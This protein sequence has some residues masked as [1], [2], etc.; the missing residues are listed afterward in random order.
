MTAFSTIGQSTYAKNATK[1]IEIL[2]KLRRMGTQYAVDLPTVVFCGNQS[3]GK[4]SLLEAISGI[5]VKDFF[6]SS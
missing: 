6:Q 3:A 4:S 1:Y 2:N 5:Q